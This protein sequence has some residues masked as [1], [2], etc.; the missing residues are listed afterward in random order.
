MALKVNK[1]G[2]WTTLGQREVALRFK[3]TTRTVKRWW[4]R[5]AWRIP[6]G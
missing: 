4:R 1:Q 3:V 2:D 6:E 5:E